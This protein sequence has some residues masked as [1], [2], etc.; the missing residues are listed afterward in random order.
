MILKIVL[1]FAAIAVA[2]IVF[3]DIYLFVV[4]Y[5]T[6]CMESDPENEFWYYMRVFCLAGLVAALTYSCI[7]MYKGMP[8]YSNIPEI[9]GYVVIFPLLGLLISPYVVMAHASGQRFS[10]TSYVIPQLF[11]SFSRFCRSTTLSSSLVP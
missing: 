9:V 6:R 4:K 2:H 7:I 3:Y 11:K 8:I 10:E 5:T 1:I